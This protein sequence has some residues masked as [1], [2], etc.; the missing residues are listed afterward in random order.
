MVRV[1]VLALVAIFPAITRRLVF[2]VDAAGD[3]SNP[4]GLLTSLGAGGFLASVVYL[5]QRY[6]AKLLEEER[7]ERIKATDQLAVSIGA[8][9]ELQ[10]AVEQGTE[11]Q[12]AQ[13]A[14]VAEMTQMLKYRWPREP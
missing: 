13:T 10:H 3:P 5:W 9:R 6:T 1:T 2:A 4:F 12:K 8:T 11:A 7:T 14:A